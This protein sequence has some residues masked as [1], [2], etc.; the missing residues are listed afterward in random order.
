M[1]DD[2][3]KLRADYKEMTGKNAFNGWGAEELQKRIDAALGG[4]GEAGAIDGSNAHGIGP[5][6]D[7][8]PNPEY[9][10]SIAPERLITVRI[11]RDIWDGDGNR[12][13][14]G[15]IVDVD[16]DTALSGVES[17]AMERVKG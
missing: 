3:T 7:G 9:A 5:D 16:V 17:G 15:T 12:H 4:D 2:I 6:T 1:S 10:P 13:R 8:G 14:K 11:V